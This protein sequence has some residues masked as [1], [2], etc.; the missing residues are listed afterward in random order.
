M[1]ELTNALQPVR[2]AWLRAAGPVLA[3]QGLARSLASVV[4]LASRFGPSVRQNA[5][6]LELGINPAV[7]VRR[8]DDGEAAG[9]LSRSS[10]G[11]DRRGKFVDLLPSGQRLADAIEVGLD[12]FRQDL[13]GDIPL[14]D[15]ETTV[16]VLRL[17]ET[18]SQAWLRE[19]ETHVRA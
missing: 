10:V 7:L 2:R 6:A 12:H 19:N 8:L 13:L 18:R 4:L 16:R 15:I 14:G 11:T 5:L 9:L 3:E 1:Q 17:L